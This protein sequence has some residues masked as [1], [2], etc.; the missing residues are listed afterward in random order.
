MGQGSAQAVEVTQTHTI[1]LSLSL[2]L[3]HTHTHTHTH[4]YMHACTLWQ[5][6]LTVDFYGS[7]I[8][9]CGFICFSEKR[10]P[11][12]IWSL[13]CIILGAPLCCAYVSLP[14]HPPPRRSSLLRICL[15]PPHPPPRRSSLLR[16]CLSPPPNP[17]PP[18][19]KLSFGAW[20]G[21]SSALLSAGVYVSISPLPPPNPSLWSLGGPHTPLYGALGASFLCK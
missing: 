18:P 6:A 4:T 13:A 16:I 14:S 20:S 1:S 9:L 10:L 17:P 12:I 2:S 7:V 3:S 15:S 21:S 11:S 19:P 5:L 8:P